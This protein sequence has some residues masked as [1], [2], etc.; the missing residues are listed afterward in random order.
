MALV[1]VPGPGNPSSCQERPRTCRTRAWL[2]VIKI[3]SKILTIIFGKICLFIIFVSLL[4]LQVSPMS[5]A[6]SGRPG[7]LVTRPFG[8]G[9]LFRGGGPWR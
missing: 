5:E 3:P 7:T 6:L 4:S 1:V 9:G 8:P 2:E